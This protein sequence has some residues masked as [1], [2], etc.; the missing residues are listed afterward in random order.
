MPESEAYS[1]QNDIT[2]TRVVSL[3][4]LSDVFSVP[5]LNRRTQNQNNEMM[6]LL[7]LL[8]PP[9][10][11]HRRSITP[12]LVLDS[13]ECSHTKRKKWE[14]CRQKGGRGECYGNPPTPSSPNRPLSL[15]VPL[16]GFWRIRDE[17]KIHFHLQSCVGTF[18]NLRS[19][20]PSPMK[21]DPNW[22]NWT[23]SRPY[24]G[25]WL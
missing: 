14:K 10:K 9:I 5:V 15:F 24:A 19:A 17:R 21:W 4:L 8:I 25:L 18:L 23:D 22:I 20:L 3:A 2:F 16:R 12:P 1:V 13:P 11:L 6:L 7:L